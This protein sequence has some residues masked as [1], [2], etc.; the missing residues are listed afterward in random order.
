MPSRRFGLSLGVDLV[1]HKTCSL[2]CVFC[3]VGPT[4]YQTRARKEYVPTSA[5]L[6]ELASWFA[7]KLPAD[8]ITV[9]GAGEPTLHTRFGEVLAAIRAHGKIRA[10][11]LTNSTLLY[12]PEVREAAAKA[13]VV[14]ATLSAWDQASFRAITQAPPEVKFEQLLDGLQRFRPI[15]QGELW[16]EVFMVPGVNTE[17]S[18]VKAIAALASTIRPDRIQLNTAV[19]PTAQPGVRA[20]SEAQLEALA[21]YFSP[22]AEVIARFAPGAGPGPGANKAAVLAMLQRRPCTAADVAQA[23]FAIGGSASS[24]KLGR[25]K[26]KAL[27]QELIA[28]GRIRA[29]ERQGETYYR[30]A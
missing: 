26:A 6:K 10:A 23:F 21:G 2:D 14:K 12:L 19:R 29:E 24:G 27:I 9:T 4:T 18:Q 20:L 17:Q 3:E 22:R 15:F 8:F 7:L 1:P 13:D 25:E 30:G 28:E 16:L 5:V 11:L